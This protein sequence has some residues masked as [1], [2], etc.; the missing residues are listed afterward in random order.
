MGST[1]AAGSALAISAALPATEDAAG[2]A[3]LTW[4]EIGGIEQI[5]GI[6]PTFNKTEFVPLKGDK[7]KHKGSVDHGA[8][9]PSLAHDDEDAGQTLLRTA[10][11]DRTSKLYSFMATYPTGEKR[12]SQGRVFGYP[13]NVG[14]ADS[15]IMANPTIELCRKVVRVPAA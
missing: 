7:D 8:L 3:A 5:G 6:G 14:N 15:V 10:S 9:Q 12:Y 11:D 2:Y 4:T 1:T 13:E